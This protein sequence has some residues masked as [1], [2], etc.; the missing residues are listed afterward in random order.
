MRTMQCVWSMVLVAM[1]TAAGSVSAQDDLHALIKRHTDEIN[2]KVIEWRRDI[3]Q[4]PELSNHEY[5]TGRK[6]AEHLKA[7]GLDV[8]TG[9]AETGVVGILRGGK[10]GKVVALRADMDAL[11][12]TEQVDVPFASKVRTTYNG[13]EV[14]VMHACG[15][16]MHVAILMGA[17]EVLT[18]MKSQ[19]NGTIVFIF[20]PAE[21]GTGGA[22]V[23]VA[24]GALK[25]PDVEAIFGLHVTQGLG[26]GQFGT[27]A[28][29]L[30]AGA[31]TFEIKI[32]GSQTHGAQPWMG[33]D[34]IMVSAQ[35]IMGLQTIVSRRSNLTVAP[36]VV[37]VATINSGVRSN[38]I[39]SEATM[40]GTIRTLDP[41]MQDDVHA[42]IHETVEGIA[43]SAGA[44]AEV[45]INKGTPITY[46]D[47]TLT[48][49]MLSTLERVAGFDHVI[50]TNPVTG[51]EDFSFYA[52]E[53]P[54]MFFFMGVRPEDVPQ[55]D[56]IPNHSP[57][58]FS[59]ESA[60]PIG[61]EA[62]AGMAVDF[63]NKA[64]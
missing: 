26:V 29:G 36:A 24:E 17:A 18:K 44:T 8:Q 48:R 40:T 51:A 37:T 19:I 22:D 52:N 62:M 10:P 4:N 5:E 27:R 30:M 16:D 60:I 56:A 14:G 9:V 13:Q 2:D 12:V 50:E 11:P 59:D 46:N 3:H 7:L 55:E 33:V 32:F 20:Q 43:K 34:P 45:T 28:G 53:I 54:A 39:P 21:E 47:A 42:K 23:M 49:S 63:L 64:D 6:V 25:D 57:F 15:H 1:V 61:V 35:V 31:D 58:F 41:A 38:I